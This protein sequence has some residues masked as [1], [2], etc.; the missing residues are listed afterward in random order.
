MPV[1]RDARN[2]PC[3]S[4]MSELSRVQVYYERSTIRFQFPVPKELTLLTQI[5]GYGLFRNIDDAPICAHWLGL[6][7]FEDENAKMNLKAF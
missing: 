3:T 6:S 7:A 4:L 2:Q 1:N 5:S